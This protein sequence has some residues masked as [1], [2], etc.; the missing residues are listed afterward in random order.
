MY[1][2]KGY[3]FNRNFTPIVK[4]CATRLGAKIAARKLFNFNDAVTV[5]EIFD[6]KTNTKERVGIV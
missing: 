4:K 6:K 1:E 5:V 3:Y 2:V